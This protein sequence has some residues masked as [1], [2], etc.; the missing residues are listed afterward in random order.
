MRI[1]AGYRPPATPVSLRTSALPSSPLRPTVPSPARSQSAPSAPPEYARSLPPLLA[2][3][4][5]SG[6]TC[7]R[8]PTL[9]LPT[10]GGSKKR[11]G[12]SHFLYEAVQPCRLCSKLEQPQR[13]RVN[14]DPSHSCAYCVL[15]KQRCSLVGTQYSLWSRGPL[16]SEPPTAGPSQPRVSPPPAGPTLRKRTTGLTASSRLAAEAVRTL[17]LPPPCRTHKDKSRKTIVGKGKACADP[18]SNFKNTKDEEDEIDEP[19]SEDE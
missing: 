8:D 12:H 19:E 18:D 9:P 3:V 13:C 1:P 2:T 7:A 16:P 10:I 5:T 4:P 14:S 6:E 17:C 15:R 11:Y